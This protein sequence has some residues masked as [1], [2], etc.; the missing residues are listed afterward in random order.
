[1]YYGE[2]RNGIA[3]TV[4]GYADLTKN[5]STTTTFSD[6][7]NTWTKVGGTWAATD[8]N[9]ESYYFTRWFDAGTVSQIKR[10]RRPDIVVDSDIEV[11]VTVTAYKDYVGSSPSATFT[12]TTA[13]AA[14]SLWGTATWGTSSWSESAD[15]AQQIVRGASLGRARA[16]QLK[17]AGPATS[18]RWSVNAINFKFIPKRIR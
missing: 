1:L 7:T 17:F 12:Y 4:V 9:V 8:G 14:G 5:V 3:G 18:K 10:W 6:G 11:T 15:G 2:V 16:V 13:A